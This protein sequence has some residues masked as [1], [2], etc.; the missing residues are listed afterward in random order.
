[1]FSLN[2]SHHYYLCSA[3]VD[4]RGGFN[5]LCGVVRSFMGR[6]PLSGD[7]FIFINKTRT[8]IKLLHWERGG[9]VIYHKRLESGT[10]SLPSFDFTT[11]SYQ[12]S[13]CDLIMMTEG[14]SLKNITRKKRYNLP[15]KIA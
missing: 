1:M 7:V 5:S 3:S 2:E 11:K 9:L 13:W 14:V 10:L 4:M 15:S 8:R 12:M 6:D